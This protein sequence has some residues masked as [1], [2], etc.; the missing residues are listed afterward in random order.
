MMVLCLSLSHTYPITKVYYGKTV[1]STTTSTSTSTPL[2][3]C[4]V[5]Y[6]QSPPKGTNVFPYVA[7]SPDSKRI[8]TLVV[9]ML[10]QKTQLQIWDATTG[11]DLQTVPLADD[12]NEALRSP[13]GRYLALSN[14]QTIVLLC[15]PTH[16]PF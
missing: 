4:S 6:T 12:L 1:S 14:L 8:A 15:R 5:F 10:S 2:P 11:G 13:T 9:N 7:W 3:A 16:S